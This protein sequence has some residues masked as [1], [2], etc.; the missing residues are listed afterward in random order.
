M[1][2]WCC[3]TSKHR[4]FEVQRA[5]LGPVTSLHTSP[6]VQHRMKRSTAQQ[7]YL[8]QPT[9]NWHVNDLPSSLHPR[10]GAPD[11][12][13]SI[14]SRNTQTYY[15]HYRSSSQPS[16]RKRHP[17]LR[18]ASSPR[19]GICR[20]TCPPLGQ[21]VETPGSVKCSVQFSGDFGSTLVWCLTSLAESSM[22]TTLVLGTGAAALSAVSRMGTMVRHMAK[23]PRRGKVG[24]SDGT[25]P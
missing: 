5:A 8:L 6:S 21:N 2:V 16:S 24:C 20:L 17:H 19:D 18:A 25:R 1:I 9:S 4:Q 7:P 12:C 10:S 15:H 22:R 3:Q 14:T 13:P 23:V 11:A